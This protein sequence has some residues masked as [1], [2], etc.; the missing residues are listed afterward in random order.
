VTN[1]GFTLAEVERFESVLAKFDSDLDKEGNEQKKAYDDVWKKLGDL[2]VTHNIYTTA[3]PETLA[4]SRASLN[5]A[6]QA[7][8]KRYQAELARQ[9]S[10]DSFCN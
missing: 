7:R 8:K 3:T 1:F 9:R 4:K 10:N 5:D 6:L 2:G